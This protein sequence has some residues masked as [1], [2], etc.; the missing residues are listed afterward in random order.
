MKLS[1][2]VQNRFVQLGI[3][4]VVGITVGAIFY[5]QKSI[6]EKVREQVKQEY[7]LKI[8]ESEKRHASESKELQAKLE[9]EQKSHREYQEEASRKIEKLVQ[10][11]STLKQSMKKQK[12]KIVK[13]D[14]T[15]VEKE[16]E[17]SNSEATHTVIT[18]VK[19]E[20]SRKI[21][22]IEDRYKKVHEERVAKLKADFDEE[23]KKAKSETKTVEV[24]REVERRV[25][26]NKK[27]LRPEIGATT[28][29]DIY[30]HGTYN[31]WGPTFIGGGVSGTDKGFGEA[32]IGLGFE[33]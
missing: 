19:E 27:S 21:K 1:E 2:L 15:I 12:L 6:E 3:A 16:I 10:E 31:L 28:D 5:P 25:E 17:E 7:E 18:Q 23:L 24:I 22:E 32:R 33:L 13:P 26:V 14:G 29:K 20:F 11:N 8:E 4:L 30:L 9:T